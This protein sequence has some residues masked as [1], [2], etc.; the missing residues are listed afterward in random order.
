MRILGLFRVQ[1]GA[2]VL[3]RV[4]DS[5]SGWCDDIYVIE[6][7]ST[8]N[9]AQILAQHPAV[10]NVVHAR[11]D[12]PAT[13]W[14]IPE[15]PGLE[16]MYR[17]A[18]FCRPDWIVM[19]DSDQVVEA[20][21]D[22]RDV[23]AGTPDDVAALMCPMI[24][25]WDDPDYPDMIP[26]MGTGESVR[27]PFWRWHPG[28]RAGTRAIH[29]PHWPANITEHGGIG[30]VN[31]IRLVHTG[32]ASL[33]ERIAKVEHYRRLDP[34][35]R[36]NFG[37]PYDRAL[38]FG[39]ASDE[40]D[41]LIAD[42]RRRR[43][44]DFD[45]AEP[46][47]RLPIDRDQLAVGCGY[48]P[49]ADAFHPGV[50]FAAQ[51]GTPIHAVTSGIVCRAD[52]LDDNGLWSVTI[53]TGNVDTVYVFR[54]DDRRGI[55]VADRIDAGARIGAIGREADSADGYLHFEVHV[56]GGH[57]SPVR[58]LANMGLQ[59]WPPRGRPRPVSG[60]YPPATP[61]TITG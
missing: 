51:P 9:T 60:T 61:C 10:T 3:P 18:D 8:D 56:D 45:P 31:E 34:D 52:N 47:T 38:L 2:D 19:I 23:L 16:L 44:G 25:T 28:L 42:Y 59:P 43:R 54:S 37:V 17:M 5:L 29:N 48:G 49:R 20:D 55:G 7:R 27:G 11:S 53:S 57:T 50:D 39:Y 24:P 46:G 6:D 35:C 13:A 26:I 40:I 4:L 21:V 12:L 22:I 41:L 1:N 15:P 33:A 30:L 14:L 36:L 58:Y 32:W